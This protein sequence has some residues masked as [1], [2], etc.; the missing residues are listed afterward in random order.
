[1]INDFILAN[2]FLEITIASTTTL[3]PGEVKTMS[4]AARAA[5][6]DPCVYMHVHEQICIL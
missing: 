2:I 5:S 6:V 1:M 3:R 4:A